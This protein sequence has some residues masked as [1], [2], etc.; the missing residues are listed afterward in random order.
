MLQLIS[1]E[2]MSL[3]V[4]GVESSCSLN[5]LPLQFQVNHHR[6]TSIECNRALLGCCSP[7]KSAAFRAV[8]V[9]FIALIASATQLSFDAV[10]IAQPS[11]CILTPSCTANADSSSVF[12]YWFRQAFFTLFTNLAPFKS[13]GESQAKFLFQTIQLGVGC[14]CFVLCL[15]YLII[16]YVTKSK[17]GN[18]VGTGQRSDYRAPQI[19]PQQQSQY[20]TQRQYQPPPAQPAYRQPRAP[21]SYPGEVPWN[22]RKY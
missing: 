7:T 20:Q 12:S 9:T 8:I 18:Q 11:T 14:L 10:F 13:Y 15:I 22:G 21:Q 2:L 17:A 4:V 16:Y 5:S 1:G 19:S 3:L 6:S